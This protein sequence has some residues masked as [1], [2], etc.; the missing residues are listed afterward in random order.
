[1]SSL[2]TWAQFWYYLD[3]NGSY[4]LSQF[5]RHFLISIYGVLIAAIIGIPVGILIAR[6]KH[7]SDTVIGLAT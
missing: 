2:S 1:M 6:H 4:V 5:T 7:L 3:H